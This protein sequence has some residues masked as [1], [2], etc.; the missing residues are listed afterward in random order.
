MHTLLQDVRYALRQF[1]RRP[2]FTAV[3]VLSLAIG[4]GGNSL[5]Y[6][7]VDGF[8]LHP[9]P[10]PDPDRLV[11]VGLTFPKFS[12]D[13]TYVETMSPARD[14]RAPGSGR[15]WWSRRSR[16]RSSSF[17]VPDSCSAAS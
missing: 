14:A 9:F 7:L 5:I 13:T 4:I 12:S 10:Y 2:G 15:S 3:A 11:A 16:C 1:A 17:W 6:G 8:V